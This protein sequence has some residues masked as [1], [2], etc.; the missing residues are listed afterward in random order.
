M[1]TYFIHRLRSFLKAL[2]DHPRRKLVLSI[3][4]SWFQYPLRPYLDLQ[5]RVVGVFN[6]DL[7]LVDD[8]YPGRDA[9]EVPGLQRRW[10]ELAGSL[11]NEHK[12]PLDLILVSLGGNDIIG[13]DL[14]RHLKRADEVAV[15][16]IWPW[17][18]E[19]PD[20]VKTHIRLPVLRASFE[21]I[22]SAYE[23]L[24]DLRKTFAPNATLITHTYA[25]VIPSNRPYK[26]AFLKTG[27]WMW[28][29]MIRVGLNDPATQRQL[30]RWLLASFANLLADIAKTNPRCIIL[31]SRRELTEAEYWD[32]EIHP[33]GAGFKRLFDEYWRPAIHAALI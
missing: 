13:K 5:R 17:H 16:Q 14:D 18:D 27:P 11:Q 33:T 32:N 30:S 23:Q 31:D 7:L 6:S 2:R 9:D 19:L 8:S 28:D 22:R 15:D 24:I 4:D 21:T 29:A 25:D 12:R 26:F 3:G 20:V 10:R 1:P